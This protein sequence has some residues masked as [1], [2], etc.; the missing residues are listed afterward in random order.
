VNVGIEENAIFNVVIDPVTGDNLQAKGEANLNTF[1]GPD[2]AVGLTGTYELKDGY[3]ELNYNFVRKKF[4]IQPGSVITLAG[5]PLDA[6]V[7][8]TAAYAAN[9]AP[10]ELV[11]KQVDQTD[12]NYYKQR[13]PFQVLL[14]LKGKV[15]KP[16]ITFDIVLP[17]DK[18]NVVSTSVAEQVQRKLIEIRNDPSILNKQVFAALIL[19][20][21]ITDDPFASGAGGGVEYAA[22]QSASRFLSDQLNALAGQLVQGFEL[23]VGLESSEDYSTGD[24][25]TRTDLNITASKRLFNDRLKVTVGNDFQL[26]GQQAQTQQSSL[27]PGNLSLDYML[28]KDGRYQVRGYRVNQLQNLVDGYV[29]E[30]GLSFRLNIEYNKFKYIFRNWD[31]YRKKREAERARQAQKN[32][33]AAQ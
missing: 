8:I 14:K 12:L 19:G 9:I 6:E 18:E 3:Y 15:M 33:G 2:G 26:E 21:F 32:G 16:E 25:S 13:L 30:T 10:Y 1:I 27:I 11:E 4:A 17:E 31:K 20:R 7:D 24:R 28:T 22:R 29:V 23:N 5:D